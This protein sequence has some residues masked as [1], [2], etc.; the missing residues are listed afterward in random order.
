MH[1]FVDYLSSLQPPTANSTNM[2]AVNPRCSHNLS[3]YIERMLEIKPTILFMGE[4]PGYR[5]CG[6]TGIPF[7]DEYT[8]ATH[9]F[10]KDH[11]YLFDNPPASEAT[12]RCVW[13]CINNVVP[14][15]WNIYPFHPFA[16][17]ERTN[18]KPNGDEIR[19]GREIAKRFMSLFPIEKIYAVGRTA[20]AFGKSVEYVRHP[21]FGG[22]RMFI[23]SCRKILQE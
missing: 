15:M 1:S 17:N 23:E 4:A 3:I 19:L 18:R 22:Q 9:P 12:A 10:F 14:L 13:S 6:I 20:Q 11:G 7:T 16:A 21:S 8:L 5:G 2:Y